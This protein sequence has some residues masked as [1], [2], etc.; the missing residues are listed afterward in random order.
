MNRPRRIDPKQAAR[1]GVPELRPYI[2][3]K[4]IEEVRREYGLDRVVKLASNECP[5]QPP[6]ELM[7]VFLKELSRLRC[8]PDGG[9]RELTRKLA[10]KLDIPT[11]SLVF[12][13]GAE[14]CIRLVAQA[15]LDHGDRA[16][17]PRPIFDAYETAA[18]LCGAEPVH[19]PLKDFRIDLEAILE[20]VDERTKLVWL[21]SPA[22]PSGTVLLKKELDRFLDR[23]PENILVVLD[24]AYRELVETPGAARAE[25]Y[26]FKDDRVIG[27]RT[28]SKVFGLAGLRIG[29]VIA[30]PELAELVAKVKLPFNVNHLAQAAAIYML[31]NPGFADEHI[32]LVRQ[33][34]ARLT[35]ELEERGQRVIPSETN[36]LFVE[37][38]LDVDLVFKRLLE[39]GFIIRPGSIW[40][41]NRFMR[42]SV[43]T[44][45]QNTE[46]LVRLDEVLA[47]KE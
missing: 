16:I 21:C 34:R 31:D 5:L 29:Y 13:N 41:H 40:G 19:V 4:P 1:S 47:A 11:E 39:K 32:G 14:E 6:P 12:G 23:L 18:L 28:F 17:Q 20:A 25:D 9:C 26:L 22:N 3:G 2:P 36:F 24:E 33:E 38:P 8:Y 37:L 10:A 42:L 45:E 27:L 43:G 15:F 35:R 30:H 46:F 44:P 7:E